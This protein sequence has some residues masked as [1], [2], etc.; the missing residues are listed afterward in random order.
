MMAAESIGEASSFSVPVTVQGSARLLA[1][2]LFSTLGPQ[3][4]SAA[5]LIYARQGLLSLATLLIPLVMSRIRCRSSVVERGLS[6]RWLWYEKVIPFDSLEAVTLGPDPRR[7]VLGRREP[8][9][10]VTR[11]KSS[12]LLLFGELRELEALGAALGTAHAEQHA[13][14]PGAPG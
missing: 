2:R 8:V 1:V 5:A 9:L 12:R 4:S 10:A 6:V 14:G 3:V 13:S 7:W 11:R